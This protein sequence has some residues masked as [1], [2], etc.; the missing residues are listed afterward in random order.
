MGIS[1][2]DANPFRSRT[3]SFNPVSAKLPR[4]FLVYLGGKLL[5]LQHSAR[6]YS[7]LVHLA[8]CHNIAPSLEKIGIIMTLKGNKLAQASQEFQHHFLQKVYIEIKGLRSL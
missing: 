3:S 5:I 2:R 6:V 4:I 8:S 7:S 1:S